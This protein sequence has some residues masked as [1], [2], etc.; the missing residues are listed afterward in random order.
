MQ[1][2]ENYPEF[3]KGTFAKIQLKLANAQ[4]DKTV[5]YIIY[6]HDI[7]QP[8]PETA[9]SPKLMVIKYLF[10]ADHLNFGAESLIK[11]EKELVLYF[12]V[13]D[14]IGNENDSE[15]IYVNDIVSADTEQDQWMVLHNC[16]KP[17]KSSNRKRKRN[18]HN[19]PGETKNR[20]DRSEFRI[21][22]AIY[23]LKRH[24]ALI[25]LYDHP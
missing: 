12:R 2:C 13:L 24:S 25:T 17:G 5:R 15:F 3:S 10:I 4:C 21:L 22:C 23:Y 16:Q 20:L 9:L 6:I 19:V 14:K 7:I 18:Y 1:P 8:F 11:K